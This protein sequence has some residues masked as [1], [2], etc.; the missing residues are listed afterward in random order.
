MN[1]QKEID[2]LL[3]AMTQWVGYLPPQNQQIS[4]AALY[5]LFLLTNSFRQDHL[6]AVKKIWAKFFSSNA[7]IVRFVNFVYNFRTFLQTKEFYSVCLNIIMFNKNTAV[8]LFVDSIV[9]KIKQSHKIKFVLLTPGDKSDPIETKL[10][11]QFE[12]KQARFM[13]AFSRSDLPVSIPFPYDLIS[14]VAE[15]LKVYP[16]G[17]GSNQLYLLIL[18]FCGIANEIKKRNFIKEAEKMPFNAINSSTTMLKAILRSVDRP[19]TNIAIALDGIEDLLEQEITA[20][21][22]NTILEGL[23]HLFAQSID[24]LQPNDDALAEAV[25]QCLSIAEYAKNPNI[26][27]LALVMLRGLINEIS[28]E[29]VCAVTL[30]GYKVRSLLPDA[31]LTLCSFVAHCD[32]S[33]VSST[34]Q[35]FWTAVIALRSSDVRTV[36]SGLLLLRLYFLRILDRPDHDKILAELS[37]NQPSFLGDFN[38]ILPAVCTHLKNQET[39]QDAL[40]AL[41]LLSGMLGF[42]IVG[43]N[44]NENAVAFFLYTLP[45]VLET[46]KDETGCAAWF[47]R[48]PPA[49]TPQKFQNEYRELLTLADELT[50]VHENMDN[51]NMTLSQR[52][53][54]HLR[55]ASA[56]LGY[57]ELNNILNDA[58]NFKSNTVFSNAVA[59]CLAKAVH[60]CP[61]FAVRCLS[62]AL[63]S[64]MRFQYHLLTLCVSLIGRMSAADFFSLADPAPLF[65]PLLSVI[66]GKITTSQHL[67]LWNMALK[68]LNW[69][70]AF[71][72]LNYNSI[73]QIFNPV[74]SGLQAKLPS[75][76][77]SLP[78]LLTAGTSDPTFS[79]LKLFIQSMLQECS[80]DLSNHVQVILDDFPFLYLCGASTPAKI[81]RRSFSCLEAPTESSEREK[82]KPII[83]K[84]DL[85]K[86]LRAVDAPELEGGDFAP[87]EDLDEQDFEENQEMEEETED[88]TNINKEKSSQPYKEEEQNNSKSNSAQA[89]QPIINRGQISDDPVAKNPNANPQV[90][91]DEIESD[92]SFEGEKE[93][94]EEN[95]T[96]E[97]EPLC[98]NDEARNSTE[99]EYQSLESPDL[100]LDETFGE[101]NT[102]KK[103]MNIDEADFKENR[104]NDHDHQAL[105]E[106]QQHFED[107]SLDE[108][109]SNV[110][111]S[112]QP[113]VNDDARQYS[114][115]QPTEEDIEE[116]GGTSEDK[117]ERI[118]TI[119]SNN[120]SSET[121]QASEDSLN[122]AN[123]ADLIQ[124]FSLC[125]NIFTKAKVLYEQ[126][127]QESKLRAPQ[128][129]PTQIEQISKKSMEK[130]RMTVYKDIEFANPNITSQEQVTFIDDALE[131]VNKLEE[132]YGDF[133][134]LKEEAE[135]KSK[136]AKVPERIA[137]FTEAFQMLL[138]IYQICVAFQRLVSETFNMGDLF[139]CKSQEDAICKQFK[140]L[141]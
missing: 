30:I 43:T 98:S 15:L 123:I 121:P 109:K 31:L 41:F 22:A 104:Q 7:N 119:S 33:E 135:T 1:T 116:N 13:K 72:S 12:E 63:Q 68:T 133:V 125:A 120:L 110:Q 53:V 128:L 126:A 87:P 101:P 65:K 80:F 102:A 103:D 76:L 106:S 37:K 8:S 75:A 134:T 99:E 122:E 74:T 97:C 14:L 83:P 90:C 137:A 77:S 141:K 57:S 84:A 4:Q 50:T 3:R 19:S 34:A 16:K 54:Y 82:P 107:E 20:T 85:S 59:G 2:T 45:L 67:I 10:F 112:V 138:Y 52:L 79:C 9:K 27:S 130:M 17:V 129:L 69:S 78:S 89:T 70:V 38:G 35:V 24:V 91:T 21:E 49:S 94:D 47:N 28:P 93:D 5:A 114:P 92:N 71:S 62:D 18:G 40:E 111:T 26:H 11:S 115:V 42:H 108:Q 127:F 29:L 118:S 46:I 86:K 81:K 124:A 6:H 36:K 136:S 88:E 48:E 51:H 105:P 64:C 66:E 58:T 73:E 113:Q 32:D 96:R 39:E 139:G 95:N 44:T 60:T 23:G 117:H 100:I 61:K 56:T 25:G 140:A 131:L 55:N 132:A